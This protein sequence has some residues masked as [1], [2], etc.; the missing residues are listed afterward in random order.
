MSADLSGDERN[1]SD[2][3]ETLCSYSDV[4]PEGIYKIEINGSYEMNCL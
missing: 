1:A 3:N 2:A 4:S